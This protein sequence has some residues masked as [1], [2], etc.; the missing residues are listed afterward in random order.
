MSPTVPSPGPGPRGESEPERLPAA[1][2]R[3]RSRSLMLNAG[4]KLNQLAASGSAARSGPRL[5]Q[6][7]PQLTAGQAH[8]QPERL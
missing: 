2:S 3:T 1:V 5:T 6:S 7:Q 4:S 8:P